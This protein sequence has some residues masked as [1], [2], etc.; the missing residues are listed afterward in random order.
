M[1]SVRNCFCV[2]HG[3]GRQL[4]EWGTTCLPGPG[5]ELHLEQAINRSRKAQ[6]FLFIVQTA[7]FILRLIASRLPQRVFLCNN[8]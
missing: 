6:S 7:P 5:Q 8:V 1:E 2:H 4:R 3:V